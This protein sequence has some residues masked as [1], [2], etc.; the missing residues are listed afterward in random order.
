VWRASIRARAAQP[1]RA[2]RRRRKLSRARGVSQ[3]TRPR[4]KT[5]PT[6]RDRRL[7][8]AATNPHKTARQVVLARWTSSPGHARP[9]DAS[10]PLGATRVGAQGHDLTGTNAAELRPGRAPCS[11]GPKRDA[12]APLH[13]QGDWGPTSLGDEPDKATTRSA[14]Q[15]SR[16]RRPARSRL[17][18][19]N[20]FWWGEPAT[21]Y[22]FGYHPIPIR[23]PHDP[24]EPRNPPI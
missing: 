4:Q 21:C 6:A 16:P 22:H 14:G 15:V 17:S 2:R 19:T 7:V 11:R 23:R 3:G 24:Q 20:G 12:L 8:P 18:R 1:S 9:H 10:T 13:G 5:D